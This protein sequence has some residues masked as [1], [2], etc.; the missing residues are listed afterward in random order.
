MHKSIQER[1]FNHFNSSKKFIIL[2]V[3]IIRAIITHKQKFSSFWEFRNIYYLIL[4][5]STAGFSFDL[6]FIN[7]IFHQDITL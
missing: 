6:V 3:I 5:V 1:L 2:L 4:L 7:I